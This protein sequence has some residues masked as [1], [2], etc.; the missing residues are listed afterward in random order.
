MSDTNQTIRNFYTK[1]I[2]QDFA[3]D[4]LF[5]VLSI[6]LAGGLTLGDSELIYVKGATLP[7]KDISNID[8]KYMGFNFNIPG[9]VSYP[10]SNGYSLDFYCDIGSN[11]RDLML[12]ESLRTF[13]DET[14]TSSIA[15]IPPLDSSITLAQLDH[16]L[17]AFNVFALKGVSIRN[18]SEIAYEIAEGTGSVKS[19][20][21][22]FAYQ[23][24]EKQ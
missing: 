14:S 5:R 11:L 18:V 7:G 13:D 2:E 1:A 9:T 23:F 24:F 10:N 21:A 6:N 4:Y 17:N 15:R 20:T 3:R 19:F 22:T 12:E 16:N 8:V